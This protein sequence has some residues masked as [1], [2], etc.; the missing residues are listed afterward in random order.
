MS[1]GSTTETGA[2]QRG[3]TRVTSKALNKVVSAVT[4]DALGVDAARVGVE[5]ADHTGAL[6][7][8]VTTPIRIVSLDRVSTDNSVVAR[9]GGTILDRAGQAQTTIRD[10]V[11]ALTG[12]EIARVTV[13]VSGVTIQ[14]EERVK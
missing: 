8:V 7:L 10:R 4:A 12:S 5:L 13:K 9:S 11:S 6:A 2:A 1:I 3:R 14:P